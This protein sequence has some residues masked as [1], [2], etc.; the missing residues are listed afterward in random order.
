MV[1]R[2]EM[3]TRLLPVVAVA[4][5]A[6]DGRVLL[7]QRRAEAHHGGLWEFPGGKIEP[8]ERPEAALVREAAEEL[9]IAIDAARLTP[10]GFASEPLGARHLVL[11]LYSTDHWEGDPQPL[12]ADALDWVRP[13]EIDAETMPPAD[14]PLVALLRRALAQE[15]SAQPTRS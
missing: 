15:P 2:D 5:V 4:L 6:N 8:G 11:L 3:T 9:G 13:E 14:R 10:V 12:D 1:D 7:A